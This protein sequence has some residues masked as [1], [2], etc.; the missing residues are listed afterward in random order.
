M[1]AGS[2]VLRTVSSQLPAPGRPRVSTTDGCH[3][4]C[5]PTGTSFA[6]SPGWCTQKEITLCSNS[7]CCAHSLYG[8]TMSVL[9]HRSKT[10][11]GVGGND[12]GCGTWSIQPPSVSVTY[13]LKLLAFHSARASVVTVQQPTLTL[14]RTTQGMTTTTEAAMRT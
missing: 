6:L 14:S 11:C 9:F 3:S 13:V 5:A 8:T 4:H 10:S 2:A 7:V 1:Y 12:L